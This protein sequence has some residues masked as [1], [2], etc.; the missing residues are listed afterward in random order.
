[1]F[2]S[3]LLTIMRFEVQGKSTQPSEQQKINGVAKLLNRSMEHPASCM[4]VFCHI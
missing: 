4:A 1:M 2:H 3:I